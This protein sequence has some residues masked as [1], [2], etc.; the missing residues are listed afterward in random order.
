MKTIGLLILTLS[1]CAGCAFITT[2]AGS[3]VGNIG[4]DIVKDKGWFDKEEDKEKEDGEQ[5]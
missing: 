3:L 1:L 4:A 2:A 5:Q